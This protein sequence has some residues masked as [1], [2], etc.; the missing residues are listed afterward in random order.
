MSLEEQFSYIDENGNL[1]SE[2]PDPR[3]KRKIKA[4]DISLGVPDNSQ[5]PPHKERSGIVKF[6]NEDK[7][8][9]FI[10]DDIDGENIFL[11]ANNLNGQ[12]REQ[13]RVTFDIQKGPKGPVAINVVPA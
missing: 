2:K 1:T 9:G 13:D 10:R 4:E 3:K 5:S 8:Y 12:V 7:G 6:Y 11:H